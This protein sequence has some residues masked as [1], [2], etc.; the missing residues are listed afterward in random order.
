MISPRSSTIRSCAISDSSRRS[1]IPSPAGCARQGFRSVS[2]RLPARCVALHPCSASTPMRSSASSATPRPRSRSFAGMA[3]SDRG[4]RHSTATAAVMA[5]GRPHRAL[6]RDLRPDLVWFLVGG[7]PSRYIRRDD[8]PRSARR[9]D[10]HPRILHLAGLSA[11]RPHRRAPREDRRTAQGRS[12]HRRTRDN[13][14]VGHVAALLQRATLRGAQRDRARRRNGGR[15]LWPTSAERL[16]GRPARTTSRRSGAPNRLVR[17]RYGRGVLCFHN[18]EQRARALGPA[19]P[20]QLTSASLCRR[21]SSSSAPWP[22]T[23][24]TPPT[25]APARSS[26]AP[27]RIFRWP[28]VSTRRSG[29]WASL[30]TTS[31]GATSSVFARGASYWRACA[32]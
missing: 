15:R 6:V 4:P 25:T 17:P 18:R 22:T 27:L 28:P 14:V 7:A 19:R 10:L 24:C 1:I 2:P 21:T 30:V 23:T 26:A 5:R 9:L 8:V 29:S 32:T 12:V 3:R 31:A 20:H 13:G 11:F 16:L